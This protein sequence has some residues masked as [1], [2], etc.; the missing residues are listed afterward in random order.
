MTVL[1]LRSRGMARQEY[2]DADE[3][4]RAS[5]GTLTVGHVLVLFVEIG[6]ERR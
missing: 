1:V 4:V 3:M 6:D 2:R 5:E